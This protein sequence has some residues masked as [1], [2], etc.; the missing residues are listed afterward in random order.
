MDSHVPVQYAYFVVC[1]VLLLAVL[2]FATVV[3]IEQYHKRLG[4]LTLP[5]LLAAIAVIFLYMVMESFNRFFEQLG[6]GFLTPLV[7]I[8]VLM[9]Y[10]AIFM[11]KSLLLKSY[12]GINSVALALLWAMGASDKITMPF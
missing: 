2:D 12:L 9:I 10:A 5:S 8:V 4:K 11:E 3:F 1:T 7:V 6:Y